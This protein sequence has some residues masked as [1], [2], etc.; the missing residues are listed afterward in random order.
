M[1]KVIIIKNELGAIFQDT[2]YDYWVTCKLENNTELRLFDYQPIDVSDYL[3]K[4]VIIKIKALFI[5]KAFNEKLRSFYGKLEEL[6]GDF[7]FK[8]DF[9]SI[10]INKEDIEAENLPL[11]TFETFY[12]GR[13]DI[14]SIKELNNESPQL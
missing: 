3:N 11:N 4:S 5:E 14:L 7:F 10:Q 1:T 8:N 6:N 2:V 13:L 12:F 9:V